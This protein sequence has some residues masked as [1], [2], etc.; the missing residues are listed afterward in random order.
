MENYQARLNAL[1]QQMK[2]MH[3]D[4]FII[5]HGDR[6][7][8]E[9][10]HPG[11][12]RL[13]HICGLDASA[14]YV[15][16]TQDKAV[17]LIDGRYK[18]VAHQQVDQSSFDIAYYTEI[19]PEEWA[20]KNLS[21]RA[22]IGYDAWLHPRYE[23]KRMGEACVDAGF[24]LKPVEVNPVDKIWKDK[25]ADIQQTACRH[26][27]IFAGATTGEKLDMVTRVLV[28]GREN[29][30]DSC[31]I[32]AP[33]SL[34]WLLNLRVLDYPE[35]P[36]LR[37][38]A[39]FQPFEKTINIFTDVDCSCFEGAQAPGYDVRF[40]GLAKLPNVMRDFERNEQT[41]AISDDTPDWFTPYL[42]NNKLLRR[43]PCALLKACKNDVEQDGIRSSHRRDG[44]AVIA[45]LAWIKA[46][47]NL[48]ER[49]VEQ[50]LA[51]ER[52][53][54]NL[55]R[56]LSF[57]SIVGWNENGAAIHRHLTDENNTMI[58]GNGLLLIDSGGQYD[59]GTTD[60]TRTVAVGRPT[61]EMRRKYT[62][63]LKSH[64]ALARA[65]F[66]DGTTGAQLDALVRSVLWREGMDF[67][68]GTG[69]GVGFFLNVH[70]GPA[71]IS[72]LAQEPLKPGMLLSNEPGYYK[73]GGFGI[74]LE[75]LM[76]VQ[77]YRAASA[78]NNETGKPLYCFET[79]TLVPFD[80][81]CIMTELLTDE[82]K[83]WLDH[84]HARVEKE[85]GTKAK[86]TTSKAQRTNRHSVAPKP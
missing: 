86:T 10:P 14:G 32:A 47:K 56:G 62:F 58:K 19:K 61:K 71:G 51:E 46:Q 28:D 78:P 60:I 31:I 79:V 30:V 33:D 34:G 23:A 72:P 29:P 57:Q 48:T 3:I 4:A 81:S 13:R 6:W 80:N 42:T 70:E 25:P 45:T 53:K 75:S 37:G 22:T 73:E 11:D 44:R 84:Y 49:D 9:S 1:R 66:P 15:V 64:I 50:K 38:F 5:P 12:L 65:I 69:H 17:V 35:A 24:D 76:L 55:F 36:G 43:D 16:V 18:V 63:V 77:H 67:A 8:S 85:M 20:I 74:R 82:E 27:T 21:R 59:D 52:A 39:I 68:H 40:H 54:N 7:M 41:I 26:D 2:E 83:Q